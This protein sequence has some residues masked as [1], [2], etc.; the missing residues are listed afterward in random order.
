[1]VP[2]QSNNST[3]PGRAAS[4]SCHIPHVSNPFTTLCFLQQSIT[5][6][7]RC[8]TVSIHCQLIFKSTTKMNVNN[9]S[10]TIHHM[11]NKHNFSAQ[12]ALNNS[13]K[14]KA[15]ESSCFAARRAIARFSRCLLR[16]SAVHLGHIHWPWGFLC[17]LTHL[18]WNH[19]PNHTRQQQKR[20]TTRGGTTDR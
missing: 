16:I 13:E 1:M 15:Q 14:K 2:F 11:R 19:S 8:P 4:L 3:M 20:P 5:Y 9:Y 7:F 10:T 12:H 18:K 6:I 17:R